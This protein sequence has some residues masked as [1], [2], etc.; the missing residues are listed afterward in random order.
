MSYTEFLCYKLKC[1]SS[2]I[3]DTCVGEVQCPVHECT[4]CT[5]MWVKLPKQFYPHIS[6]TTK[7]FAYMMYVASIQLGAC[8]QT[9]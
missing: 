4:P 7:C 9:F 2:L 3:N 6:C 8:R 1:M 5:I